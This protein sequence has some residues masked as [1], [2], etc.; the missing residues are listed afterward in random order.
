MNEK[1]MLG[2]FMRSR[3]L[4]NFS[5]PKTGYVTSS[6]WPVL[7]NCYLQLL[8]EVIWIVG[9]ESEINF[10]HDNWIGYPISSKIHIPED[11]PTNSTVGSFIINN[12]WN[13]PHD[14]C[15]A[16]PN[17]ARDILSVTS[18]K[19]SKDELRWK[20]CSSGK[21]R[22]RDFYESIRVKSNEVYWGDK[23]WRKSI[24][25]RRSITVWKALHDRLPTE[26]LL[27]KKGFS[28]FFLLSFLYGCRGRH[29]TSICTLRFCQHFMGQIRRCFPG[30]SS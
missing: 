15:L 9:N 6:L 23:I 14:F 28:L 27:Q 18:A 26:N 11:V 16:F 22:L 20:F 5:T 1:G 10:W 7:C 21:P 17:V 3:Y 4:K 13:L 19:N 2:N 24:Q 30:F 8:R 29:T 25:P 12:K